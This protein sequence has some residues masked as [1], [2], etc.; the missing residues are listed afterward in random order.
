MCVFVTCS[1]LYC[2]ICP[3][4]SVARMSLFCPLYRKVPYFIWLEQYSQTYVN[5]GIIYLD[6][7][8]AIRICGDNGQWNKP[9][10]SEC[11]IPELR[12]IKTEVNIN[13]SRGLWI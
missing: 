3:A 4:I 13:L 1:N 11:I 10:L 2:I 12:V 6:L 8:R 9:D 7:G 5:F